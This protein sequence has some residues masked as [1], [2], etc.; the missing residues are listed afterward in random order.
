MFSS[1]TSR[2]TG[3]AVAVCLGLVGITYVGL[4]G[5]RRGEA[6]DLSA[7]AASTQQQ[8]DTLQVTI[9][10]LK[11]QY[12]TLPQRRT[13]LSA[14]LDAMPVAAAV[15]TFVRS[16]DRLASDA[17]VRLDGVTPG[18]AR[19]IDA[20][21]HPADVAA[22]TASGPAG[23]LVGVPVSLVVHGPYFKAVTFLKG[24]QSASRAYLVTGVQ[25]STDGP[26]VTLTV[27][28]RVFA[29]PGAAEALKT[30]NPTASAAPSPAASP[31]S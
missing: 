23:Q 21:G 1:P 10:Q 29:L 5:P 27:R 20:Q 28:G 4:V 18:T 12:A 11:A 31:A 9:A 14:A 25:V 22:A 7:S 16:L 8:N 2:W 26:D 19:P 6:D 13:E 15:P 3:G 30:V 17:G 24:L